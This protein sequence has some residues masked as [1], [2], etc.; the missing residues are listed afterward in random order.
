MKRYADTSSFANNDFKIA[1]NTRNEVSK[2]L[3]K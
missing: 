2:E 1:T 3:I